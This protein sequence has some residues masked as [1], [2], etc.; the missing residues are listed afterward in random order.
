MENKITEKD[1]LTCFTGVQPPKNRYNMRII[2]FCVGKNRYCYNFQIPVLQGKISVIFS[3]FVENIRHQE[4]PLILDKTDLENYI[5]SLIVEYSEKGCLE[6]FDVVK[7]GVYELSNTVVIGK[8]EARARIR[9]RLGHKEYKLLRS[10]FVKQ[11]DIVRNIKLFEE[12]VNKLV[13]VS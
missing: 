8:E 7:V 1:L 2:K 9:K 5:N 12:Q 13:S 3:S 6:Y 10:C 4:N 11:W